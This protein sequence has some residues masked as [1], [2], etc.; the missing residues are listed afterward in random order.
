MKLSESL[1]SSLQN[2][3]SHKLRSFLTLLGIIIGVFAVVTMFSSI[4]GLKNMIN[5]RMEGMGWNNSIIIYPS[6]GFSENQSFRRRRRFRYIKREAK[7]LTLSD[8]QMLE[9]KVDAKYLYGM[10]EIYDRMLRNEKE[11]NVRMRA[12]NIAYFTSKTYPLKS[13]R[14][15]S[16]FEEA[17]ATKVCVI[18]FHFAEEHFEDEDPLGKILCIGTNRFKIIGVLDDDVLN[19]AGMNFNN[20]ERRQDLKSIYVNKTQTR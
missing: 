6:E 13:G 7:P 18:G 3:F 19:R 5:D 11:H 10:V 9:E 17:N 14:Y 4:Y 1:V 16:R 12:T 8:F 20:W 15:F 2:I